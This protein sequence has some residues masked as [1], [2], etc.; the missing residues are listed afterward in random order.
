MCAPNC[1]TGADC[2]TSGSFCC[3]PLASN[4]G[5]VCQPAALAQSRGWSCL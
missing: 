5:N 3:V 2:G 1:T 4:L